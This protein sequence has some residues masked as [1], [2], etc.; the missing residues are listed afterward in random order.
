[1]PNISDKRGLASYLMHVV[2]MET[3]DAVTFELDTIRENAG[4]LIGSFDYV[5]I[6][7]LTIASEDIDIA[8]LLF[9]YTMYKSV[10]YQT[11]NETWR[12]LAYSVSETIADTI[13]NNYRGL[14]GEEM[15]ENGMW[16]E[17]GGR[18]SLDFGS[19]AE[20]MTPTDAGVS[21]VYAVLEAGSPGSMTPEEIYAALVNDFATEEGFISAG[22]S[23][24]KR[25]AN[26]I[27]NA[28]TGGPNTTVEAMTGTSPRFNIDMLGVTGILYFFQLNIWK[29]A[30]RWRQVPGYS[31]KRTTTST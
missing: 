10:Y 20:V 4:G 29:K 31:K 30:L 3:R 19:G 15:S 16:Y 5:R 22:Y 9:S 2:W 28:Y 23:A 17:Y 18:E 25:F 14:Y 21:A 1:M 13:I 8:W 12:T 6:A 11:G 7:I 26:M 27:E 24:A